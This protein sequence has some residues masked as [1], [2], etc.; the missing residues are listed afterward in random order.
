MSEDKHVIDELPDV[1]LIKEALGFFGVHRVVQ[2]TGWAV[3][4]GVQGAKNDL[5]FRKR[6][7]AQGVARITAFRAAADL[8]KFGVY[9]E[10]KYHGPVTSFEVV[11]RLRSLNPSDVAMA[12]S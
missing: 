7:E 9:L 10:T 12:V 6:L 2:L 11:E 3:L 4:W 1:V 5:A 8:R